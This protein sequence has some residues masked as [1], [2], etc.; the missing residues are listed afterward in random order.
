MTFILTDI[1]E[2]GQCR[3]F[4]D[5]SSMIVGVCGI[6]LEEGL[7][8]LQ[9]EVAEYQEWLVS[10]EGIAKQREDE[11]SEKFKML[12]ITRHQGLLFEEFDED[13]LNGLNENQIRTLQEIN[14]ACD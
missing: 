1:S 2:C 9:R 12:C 6:C 7:Q 14:F 3:E 5:N 4:R 10:P 8:R 11:I 13:D